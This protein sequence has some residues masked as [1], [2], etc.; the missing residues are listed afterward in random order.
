MTYLLDAGPLGL[1][2]HSRSTARLPIQSWVYQQL[3]D[4]N[5]V[6]ISEVADYEV[7]REL[8]RL[9]Q[10][11]QLPASRLTRLDALQSFCPLTLLTHSN[12]QQA[13]ELWASMRNQGIPTSELASLDADVLVIS[14]TLELDATVV[15]VNPKHFEVHCKTLAW[16]IG[17][18]SP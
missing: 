14:Q 10:K 16:P 12:W 5:T 9:I 2:A 18:P 13:A 1:L 6:L 4:G 11:Q 7:R 15:T 8:I 17:S 3:Q